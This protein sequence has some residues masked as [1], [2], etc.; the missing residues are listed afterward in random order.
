MA[1]KLS[2]PLF[3][4]DADTVLTTVND[5]LSKVGLS[6]TREEALMLADRR[7]ASLASTERVEY[8]APALAVIAEAVATSPYL[9]S[10]EVPSVLARL[11]D[12]F[13]ALRDELSVDVPDAEIAEALRGWFDA[14]DDAFGASEA[15]VDEVMAFSPAYVR[16]Q[17]VAGDAYRIV[18]DEGRAYT[19]DPDEWDYDEQAK[20]WE[21]ERWAD[22]WDD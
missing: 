5:R 17:E 20:G 8:G 3:S 15:S 21:G 1:A 6:I 22:D 11:Q 4:A 9:L 7:T 10:S 2:F 13:Y 19:F 18:D 12:A 16:A 14:W